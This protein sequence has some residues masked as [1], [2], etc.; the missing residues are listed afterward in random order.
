M[1]PGC[2][3]DEHMLTYIHTYT[4]THYYIGKQRVLEGGGVGCIAV[5]DINGFKSPELTF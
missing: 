2:H 3:V 4:H 1:V 5:I